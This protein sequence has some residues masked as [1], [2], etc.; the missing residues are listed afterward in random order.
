MR[1][2]TS[3]RRRRDTLTTAEDF[4]LLA[5]CTAP[6][7]HFVDEQDRRECWEEHKHELLAACRPGRR[8]SAWWAYD[9]PPE[10]RPKVVRVDML[11]IGRRQY[12]HRVRETEAECL[13][14]TGEATPADVDE[15]R[16]DLAFAISEP[17]L[18]RH[19]A[20]DLA[21]WRKLLAELGG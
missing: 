14:R 17:E 12:P 3:T 1:K 18:C 15:L 20:A 19:S 11:T 13:I 9:Q 8:P 21:R 16:K 4:E 7:R 5:Q 10:N 6:P 2:T